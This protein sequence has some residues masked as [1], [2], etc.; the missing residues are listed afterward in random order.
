MLPNKLYTSA[1][2]RDKNILRLH[3]ADVIDINGPSSHK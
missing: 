2:K 3:I 1:A